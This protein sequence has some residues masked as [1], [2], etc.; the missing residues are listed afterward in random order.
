MEFGLTTMSN[1]NDKVDWATPIDILNNASQ[2]DVDAAMR[3][4]DPFPGQDIGEAVAE[5]LERFQEMG[6]MPR[7]EEQVE[8]NHDDYVDQFQELRDQIYHMSNDMP[9]A[10]DVMQ[11]ELLNVIDE[12]C[13]EK[14]D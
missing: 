14:E 13:P 2:E 11:C 4:L 8:M 9:E 12:L 5:A 6:I 10:F 3:G 1:K 7:D